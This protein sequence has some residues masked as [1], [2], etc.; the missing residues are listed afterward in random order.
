MNDRKSDSQ[1]WGESRINRSVRVRSLKPTSTDWYWLDAL[2][3]AALSTLHRPQGVRKNSRK[4]N[5]RHTLAH[6]WHTNAERARLSRGDPLFTSITYIQRRAGDSNPD[7][8]ADA[9]FQDRCISRSANPP[10]VP[11]S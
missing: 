7:V 8:L 3:P 9:G 11:L 2:S 4:W 1:I 5:M 6:E 10:E